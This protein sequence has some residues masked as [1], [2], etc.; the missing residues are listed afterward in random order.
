MAYRIEQFGDVVLPNYDPEIDAGSGEAVTRLVDLAGGGVF[1]ALGTDEAPLKPRRISKRAVIYEDDDREYLRT[2]LEALKA[3]AGKKEV[4]FATALDS[5]AEVFWA[6]ARLESVEAPRRPGDMYTQHVILNW[7]LESPL[8][9]GPYRDQWYLD[10]G[11]YLDAGLYL[12]EENIYTLNGSPKSITLNNGGNATVTD[13]VI[14]VTAGS[15]NITALKVERLVGSTV[16][17]QME[18]SG[19]VTA[20]KA[21]V[22]DCGMWSVENDG[23]S[24][25]DD[26]DLGTSHTGE[27]WLKLLPGDNSI[28]VTYTCAS[29]DSTIAF[30]YYDQSK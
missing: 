27:R 16:C 13:I 14:T 8:W 24:A 2:A 15:S 18:F 4:L 30:G 20:S 17:E 9:N 25:Y 21:L 7:M 26:F 23:V 12:D 1:D 3:Y 5:T 11:H 19:T 6:Y 29:A 22:I 28:R 10:D